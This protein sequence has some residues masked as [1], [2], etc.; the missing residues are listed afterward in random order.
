MGIGSKGQKPILGYVIPGAIGGALG[1]LVYWLL[2]W[3]I[4]S[5]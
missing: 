2:W 4:I 3:I 1:Y 5:G